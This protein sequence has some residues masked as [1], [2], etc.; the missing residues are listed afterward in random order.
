VT[1]FFTEKKKSETSIIDFLKMIDL[2]HFFLQIM[3]ISMLQMVS[4][5]HTNKIIFF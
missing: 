2:R 1:F 3:L 5:Y 4:L